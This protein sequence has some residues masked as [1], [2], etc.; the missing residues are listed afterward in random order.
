M[1]TPVGNFAKEQNS[2]V[3]PNTVAFLGPLALPGVIALESSRGS[4]ETPRARGLPKGCTFAPK[5]FL[6][7]E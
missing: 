2:P 6:W 7:N 4:I 1:V 5:I 3:P